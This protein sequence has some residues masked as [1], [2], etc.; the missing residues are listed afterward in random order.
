[1]RT[2]TIGAGG[3]V[4]RGGRTDEDRDYTRGKGNREDVLTLMVESWCWCDHASAACL[5]L[6]QP[7]FS[8]TLPLMPG[9]VCSPRLETAERRLSGPGAFR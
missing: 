7:T 3:Q 5:P 9:A 1:M 6:F 2:F 4:N 8:Q